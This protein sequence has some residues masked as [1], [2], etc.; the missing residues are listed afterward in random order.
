MRSKIDNLVPYDPGLTLEQ[1]E[2]KLG[3]PILKLASNES[4]WGPTP[5]L[6]AYL[7]N[8]LERLNFYPDGTGGKLKNILAEFWGLSSS[9][10]C[11]GNGADELI[12]MLT[13]AFLDPC[14]KVIIPTPT[15]SSYGIA[16]TIV[17]GQIIEVPQK[18][19][20]IKLDSLVPFLTPEIKM[21]FLCNPNNPTGTYFSEKELENFLKKVGE[22]TL[23]ILD[24]A[25]IDY[26]QAENFPCSRKLVKKYPNL[27]ILRTFSKAYGLAG[28]RVG[29]A[30]SATKT[31]RQL[32]K[33]RPPYNVN[34]LAQEAAYVAFQ[35]KKYLTR[36]IKETCE[37]REYL[38]RELT[39]KGLRVLSSQTN[40]ILINI[41]NS[42]VVW[43][44]LKKEG[45]LVRKMTSFGLE[46]WLRIT[47]PPRKFREQL[48]ICL[49]KCLGN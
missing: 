26:V 29:Y 27:V 37:E 34:T 4:L 33:V 22:E 13:A 28:L 35:D 2:K 46:D 48:L 30:V 36:V 8:N 49:E 31:I 41:K 47:V 6:K 17:G 32:E 38:I 9:N 7:Q 11:L 10:L 39:P 42:P 16:V 21:I 3:K 12:F 18:N 25:Y 45:I 15:F 14:E 23:I 24:E 40:F 5:K 44:K 43:E 1:L 20:A 19:L